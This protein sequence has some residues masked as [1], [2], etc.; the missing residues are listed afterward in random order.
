MERR[1]IPKYRQ[2]NITRLAKPFR[3][4]YINFICFL[5]TYYLNA[6]ASFDR[7]LM[8][9]VVLL[10]FRKLKA[11]PKQWHSIWSAAD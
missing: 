1:N 10:S 4:M 5:K 8:P 6:N 3:E 11:I 7:D 9:K 2:I